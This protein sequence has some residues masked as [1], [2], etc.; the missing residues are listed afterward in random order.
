[1]IAY[2]YLYIFALHYLIYR[3]HRRQQR[4]EALTLATVKIL[5]LIAAS[6]LMEKASPLDLKDP[7]DPEDPMEPYN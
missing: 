5:Q 3:Q 1:M 2:I 6:S 4:H 7:T